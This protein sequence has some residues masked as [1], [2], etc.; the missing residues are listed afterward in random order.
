MVAA[1]V[2]DLRQAEQPKYVEMYDRKENGGYNPGLLEAGKVRKRGGSLDSQETGEDDH[3]SRLT[4]ALE[5]DPELYNKVVALCYLHHLMLA[6]KPINLLTRYMDPGALGEF[7]KELAN[8]ARFAFGVVLFTGV[9][10]VMPWIYGH[11]LMKDKCDPQVVVIDGRE[12]SIAHVGCK[13]QQFMKSPWSLTMGPVGLCL[14][15]VVQVLGHCCSCTTLRRLFRPIKVQTYMYVRTVAWKLWYQPFSS[16]GRGLALR[17]TIALW[18]VLMV[19]F[20]FI[21]VFLK[22]AVAAVAAYALG[23]LL[24]QIANVTFSP[25][26]TL[27]AMIDGEFEQPDDKELGRVMQHLWNNTKK[28]VYLTSTQLSA[29][30]NMPGLREDVENGEMHWFASAELDKKFDAPPLYV[31]DLETPLT[32]VYLT[33]LDI[34]VPLKEV[35]EEASE[36]PSSESEGLTA[37]RHY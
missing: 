15:C 35:Y 21:A 26:D 16:E 22:E 14:L 11:T 19:E 28:C 12:E 13:V 30:Y 4:K 1:M 5:D 23:L 32:A 6:G 31:D 8:R 18:V 34:V 24:L 37:R 29:I 2:R 3:D 10:T 20:L 25:P 17:F 27:I 7:K 36:V 33:D 9:T